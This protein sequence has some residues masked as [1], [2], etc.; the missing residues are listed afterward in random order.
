M[1]SLNVSSNICATHFY[2][3]YEKLPNILNIQDVF[4]R[5]ES[6]ASDKFLWILS[7]SKIE[8]EIR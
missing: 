5:I 3:N 8:S 6:S 7:E 4:L 2:K 1:I